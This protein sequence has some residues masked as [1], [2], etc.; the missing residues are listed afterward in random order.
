MELQV[1]ITLSDRLFALLETK[2]PNLGRRIEKTVTKETAAQTRAESSVRVEVVAQNPDAS[3]AETPSETAPESPEETQGPAADGTP[4]DAPAAEIQP[5][6]AVPTLEDCRAAVR[7]T[8]VRFEGEGY[9]NKTGEGYEKY[10]KAITSQIKQIVFT[11][12]GGTAEKIPDLA[13]DRRAAFIAEC[14]ALTLD[15]NGLIVPPAA[16]Y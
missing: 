7:R 6:E 16:P 14:D 4:D 8:R 11:V 13:E 10:H 2:L 1:T 3:V 12:S 15:D 9:E 5:A